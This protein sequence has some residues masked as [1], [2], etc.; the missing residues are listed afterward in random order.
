MQYSSKP[1]LI[2]VVAANILLDMLQYRIYAAAGAANANLAISDKHLHEPEMCSPAVS[3]CVPQT[4][5][6]GNPPQ[7]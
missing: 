6:L 2:L 5:F 4:T 7:L 3:V 1:A